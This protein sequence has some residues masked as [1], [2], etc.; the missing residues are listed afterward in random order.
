MLH[1]APSPRAAVAG[2]TGRVASGVV[3]T[4]ELVH[5]PRER[6]GHEMS[7]FA[8]SQNEQAP[9]ILV[10][11]GGLLR[12]IALNDRCG[13]L[14]SRGAERRSPSKQAGAR[15]WPTIST[16][17]IKPVK[18]AR[19]RAAPALRRAAIV[20]PNRIAELRANVKPVLTQR[21]LSITLGIS[22]RQ[23][24][25]IE[26]GRTVPDAKLL[27]RIAKALAVTATEIYLKRRDGRV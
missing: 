26:K 4:L 12:A 16:R 15:R 10:G 14:P 8:H 27:W 23:L 1:D 20:F 9:R 5:M 3:H 13:H 2:Q 21:R 17:N 19:P 7:G 25:R 6:T 18:T 11:P 22:E 24:R